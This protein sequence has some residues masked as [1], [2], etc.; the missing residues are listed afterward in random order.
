MKPISKIV[1]RHLC[2][3]FALVSLT[4]N[5]P[6]QAQ[7]TTNQVADLHA[8]QDTFAELAREVRPSVVAIS[9]RKRPLYGQDHNGYELPS[10]SRGIVTSQGSGLILSRDGYILTNDHVLGD[11]ESI[12]VFLADGRE[13]SA[14]L[15]AADRRR[16]LAVITIQAQNLAP[17]RFGDLSDVSIGHWAIAVGNPFGLANEGEPAFTVG[18]VARLGQAPD[19]DPTRYYGN[20]IQTSAAINPGNSGGPLFDIDGRVIGVVTAIETTSGANEGVGFAIPITEHTQKII[21]VLMRGER[22]RYGYLGVRG[23]TTDERHDG[24]NGKP[25]GALITGF[26]SVRSPAKDAGLEIADV[27][28]EFDGVAVQNYDHLV[29]LVGATEVRK[30]VTVSVRRNG[31]SRTYSVIV[32]ERPRDLL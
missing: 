24:Q 12:S 32:S 13:Y 21:R 23:R 28:E 15:V 5:L 19:L 4:S 1:Q 10:S 18:N 27:I 16:D 6:A 29:R 30:T 31:K 8:L 25:R 22:V 7:R 26:P 11:C 17:V 9:A 20:L 2:I 3:C 14:E